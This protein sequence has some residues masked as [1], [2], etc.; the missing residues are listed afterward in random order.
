MV[1]PWS[2]A[3]PL[4][5][6]PL[7]IGWMDYSVKRLLMM[8]ISETL[9]IAFQHR[10]GGRLR[11]AE[12]VCRQILADEP[13]QVDAIYLLGLIAHQRDRHEIAVEHF[14]RAIGLNGNVAAFHKNLG[15]AYRALH[16]RRILPKAVACCRRALEL[17]P[18]YVEAHFNLGNALKDQGKLEDAA[19]CYRRALKLKPDF[20]PAHNNLGNALNDQ[21]KLEEAVA[22]YR[23]ALEV[24][25][26]YAEAHNNLGN[27]LKDQGKLEEAVTCYRRAMELKPDYA[28]AHAN[29]GN[30][31][32]DQRKLEDAVACYRRALELKPE[33]AEAH[34]NLGGAL[35][36]Q[37]KLEEAIA[38]YRR[39]LELKPD[40]AEAHNNLGD[41]LKDQRKLEE[42][43]ACYRRALATEAGLCRGAQQSGQC[44]E[45]SGEVGGSGRLLSPRS[46]PEAGLSRGALQPGR[47]V[48]RPGEAGG[49]GRLLPPR[50]GTETGPCQGAQQ[51]GCALRGQGKPEEA[52][53]C[54]RRALELKPDYAAA[55]AELG[56]AL[57]EMGDLPGAEDCC[58][59]ALRHDPRSAFAYFKLAELLGG[60]L[61]EEDLA[62]Q[63]R[64]LEEV[65]LP[66]AE[67]LWLH[68][69]LA[70][71][72]D[73][74]GEYAEA[75][76]HLDRGNAL[77]LSQWQK[78]G[79]PYD[80]EKCESTVNRMIAACTPDFFQRVR[81][82]GSESE[83]PVFVVGL[84]RS[85][86]TLV[87]QI[88]ASHSQVFGAGELELVSDTAA[89]LGRPGMHFVEGL[90]RLD[91]DTARHLAS[92]H[93]ERL[94]ALS[95]DSLRIVDKMPGNYLYS[96]SVG[97]PVSAGEVYPLPPRSAR[98]GRLLLDDAFRGSSLGQRPPAHCLA[99]SR[100]PTDDGAL[101]EGFAGAAV[102]SGLRGNSGRSGRRG[103]KAG[104]LVRPGVGA[105]LPAVP[106]GE[107]ASQNGQC[108]PGSPAGL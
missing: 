97:D 87:E 85:G 34:N 84:P 58:R 52:I 25:P 16:M 89:A 40:Y 36:G 12:Q 76:E 39:A 30:A 65:D 32:K 41:A 55:H 35:R 26:G 47:C 72:L 88:L 79:R 33:F 56:A 57:G 96:G 68:F 27:V 91:R 38:C 44:V 90:R 101:A 73:A 4:S 46:H 108:R 13:N 93:L 15:E 18:D 19:A 102:G 69:G 106:P 31:L 103:P 92:R 9:A 6:E 71:V 49:S 42:A 23:R 64:L 82:F 62:A 98:R 74:R 95:C 45:R 78:R 21:G 22:C 81:G 14:S 17:R 53:A 70:H 43:V 5:I 1:R 59:A 51:P 75:A 48:E 60:K 50:A 24:K 105:D 77:Q 37:G 107:A 10:Q 28:E 7:L 2:V 67:R 80:P 29:L 94:R 3:L 63:R 61:P 83:L 11:A 20:A 99:I 54:Y 104:G 66:D 100:V 8:T 86:T